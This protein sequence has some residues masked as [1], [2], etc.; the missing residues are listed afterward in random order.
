[1]KKFISILE[2]TA[3]LLGSTAAAHAQTKWGHDVGGWSIMIDNSNGGCFAIQEYTDGSIVRIGL[4]PK[5]HGVK[6]YF[7]NANWS[8]I[9]AGKTFNV[10]FVFD[11]TSSYDGDMN[12]ILMGDGK[13]VAL[14]HDHVSHAFA[15]DF[16]ERSNLKLFNRVDGRRL[17]NLSLANT[18]AAL[19]EVF[20][21]Q[22]GV[23]RP[24]SRPLAEDSL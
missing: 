18:S 14:V 6:L 19:L 9:V 21:C 11:G 8:A 17:A 13:T 5:T 23:D 24:A 22:N 10:R 4:V 1:M 3:A 12:S 16:A 15:T 2:F 20:N 7:G